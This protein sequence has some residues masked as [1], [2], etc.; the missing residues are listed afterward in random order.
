[1]I[2]VDFEK[3]KP[4]IPSFLHTH[5]VLLKSNCQAGRV[6]LHGAGSERAV[7]KHAEA[8][9]FLSIWTGQR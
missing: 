5:L 2:T 3:P 9:P 1:M 7:K 6:F 8:I 4:I